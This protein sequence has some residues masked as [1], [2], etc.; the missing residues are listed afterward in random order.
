[1]VSGPGSVS[2]V[3]VSAWT[4]TP[5]AP[6]LGARVEGADL[7]GRDVAALQRLGDLLAEHHVLVVPGQHGLDTDG[8]VAIAE[9]FGEPLVHPFI[10]AFPE[11]QA[12]LEVLTEPDDVEAF[13]G[14]HWH[15]DISFMSPPAAVSVLHGLE[16]PTTGGDTLFA[17]QVAAF[18]ALDEVLAA[19]LRDLSATHVYPGMPEGPRTAAVHPVVRRHGP[20][21]AESL[22]V[23]PAF[24]RRI[25]GLGRAESEAMLASLYAHQVRPEF[26]L[27]VSWTAGQVVLWDNRTT[28]R[29][30][31][32]NAGGRRLLRRV[33]A[34]EVP[35]PCES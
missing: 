31:V 28:L 9:H 10:D 30:A 3:G 22:Y 26:R 11:H 35:A 5:L 14:E 18:E 7:A 23:N 6:T 12:V 29:H 20:T 1:V 15:C 34:I 27:R 8:L 17:N 21:G 16:I 33:T 2:E 19:R 25:E 24:V 32:N 4:V 13:G